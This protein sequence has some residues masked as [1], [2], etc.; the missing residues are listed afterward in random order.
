V[1]AHH[2][3]VELKNLLQDQ[4]QALAVEEQ[5]M[6]APHE[7]P[8]PLVQAEEGETRQ[9]RRGEG[10]AARPVAGQEALEGLRLPLPRYVPPVFLFPEER[11]PRVHHLERS[12]DPLPE[13]RRAED[14]MPL[15][16]PLPGATKSGGI[17]LPPQ[18][19]AELLE[20]G[21]GFRSVEPLEEHP[22]LERR[23]RV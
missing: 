9:R 7:A 17:E 19:A 13:K 10:E 20:V 8:L 15:H 2:S 21:L 16:D 5:V 1:A 23:E 22:F 11:H 3:L 6:V 18:S 14:R 12:I 4:R